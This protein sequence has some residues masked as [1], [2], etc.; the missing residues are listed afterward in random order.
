MALETTV[1]EMKKELTEIKEALSA[2][3]VN[4]RQDEKFIPTDVHCTS[5]PKTYASATATEDLSNFSRQHS[6]TSVRLFSAKPSNPQPPPA[7]KYNI[8]LYGI[9]ECPKGTAKTVRFKNDLD[10]VSSILSGLDNVIQAQSVSDVVRLGKYNHERTRPRPILVKLL[11][12]VDVS[13]VLTRRRLLPVV[14]RIKL[15]L[16]QKERLCESMLL[17]ER[18]LLIQSGTNR[19]S[20]KIKNNISLLVDNKLY[21][22]WN[23]STHRLTYLSPDLPAPTPSRNGLQEKP[24]GFPSESDANIG[25]SATTLKINDDATDNPQQLISKQPQ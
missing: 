12:S 11:R 7:S 20:I 13:T 10:R 21:A 9:E 3:C 5:M 8:V 14:Y 22:K 24:S 1:A 6:N 25:G 2:T 23:K 4:A 16:S 19:S 15:F 18:W 17:K